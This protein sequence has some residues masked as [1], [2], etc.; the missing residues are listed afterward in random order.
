MPKRKQLSKKDAEGTKLLRA[1]WQS[2]QRKGREHVSNRLWYFD[3]E[4]PEENLKQ[5]KL[6]IL[7]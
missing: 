1:M 4:I 6:K 7:K 2:P 3:F 5:P